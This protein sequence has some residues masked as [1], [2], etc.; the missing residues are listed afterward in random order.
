MA[1]FTEPATTILIID[2]TTMEIST[3]YADYTNASRVDKRHLEGANI[4]F[5]D[6]HVKWFKQT[7]ASMWTR[8][9]D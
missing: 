7:K 4:A 1:A 8:E 9:E 2:C 5:A 3:S 6:G